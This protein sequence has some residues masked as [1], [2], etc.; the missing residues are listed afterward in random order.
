MAFASMIKPVITRSEATQLVTL[1]HNCGRSFDG[2]KSKCREEKIPANSVINNN[3]KILYRLYGAIIGLMQY[4]NIKDM[5]N[6]T[7]YSDVVAELPPGEKTMQMLHH[8]V[9]NYIYN[10]RQIYNCENLLDRFKEE[11]TCAVCCVLKYSSFTFSTVYGLDVPV[12]REC[13]SES[14][15]LDDDERDLDYES[16]DDED[17]SASETESE[18][19]SASASEADDASASEAD[20]A[21]ASETEADSASETESEADDASETEDDDE[22]ASEDDESASE[23]DDDDESESDKSEQLGLHLYKKGWQAGWR[24]AMKYMNDCSAVDIPPPSACVNC[25]D[26]TNKLKRCG[27]TC[28]GSVKYCSS[29]CQREHWKSVH[30]HKCQRA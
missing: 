25:G 17:A 22:S 19:D 5:L 3:D 10:H 15:G 26:V 18:A 30:K 21:S 7:D 27:G 1:Y 2:F 16:E 20:S 14:E 8:A 24:A 9:D 11:T 13:M 23:E 28:N 12:C 29:Q 4:V 6:M